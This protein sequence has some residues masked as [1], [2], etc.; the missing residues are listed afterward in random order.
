MHF[1]PQP[2]STGKPFSAGT[3]KALGL[4]RAI[5]DVGFEPVKKRS[6]SMTQRQNKRFSG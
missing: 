5:C 6:V 3:G 1:Y 2:A 4:K